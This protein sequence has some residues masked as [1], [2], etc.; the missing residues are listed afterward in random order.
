MWIVTLHHDDGY[1]KLT[2]QPIC[3][4]ASEEAAHKAGQLAAAYYNNDLDNHYSAGVIDCDF[5][6]RDNYSYS[7]K[8]HNGE[9]I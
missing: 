7:V 4:C 6:L 2:Y 9:W 8:E 5:L 3:G 1:R